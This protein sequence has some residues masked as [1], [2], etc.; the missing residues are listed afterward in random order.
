MRAEIAVI[1]G[2][3][4]YDVD[5]IEDAERIEIDTP[6]GRSPEMLVGRYSGRKIVFLPRHGKGH[7]VPPH[8]VNYRANIWALKEL[9]V[10]RVIATTAVGSLNPRMKPGQL[11]LLDQFVDFTKR[12]PTTFYEGGEKGVVHVDMS[13]PYCP[14]LRGVMLKTARGLNLSLR[15]GATYACTEGPRFETPAEI[16]MI[17]RAGCDVV[18]MTNVPESILARELEMCYAAISIV[19]NFAAGISKSKLTSQEVMDIM[20]SNVHKVKKLIFSAVPMIPTVRSCPC[21]KALEGAFVKA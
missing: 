19:T 14:E 7:T 17:R 4:I 5:L 15:P 11:V 2:S 18:G 1:G 6:Y 16:K 12:R 13:V 10:E 8:L 21:R 20:A 9:G 3:G